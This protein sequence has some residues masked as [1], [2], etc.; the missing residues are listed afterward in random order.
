MGYTRS[1]VCNIF[2]HL[3]PPRRVETRPERQEYKC[4]CKKTKL[5]QTLYAYLGLVHR[6]T[7]IFLVGSRSF[8][9]LDSL[10]SSNKKRI[11]L[12]KLLDLS[13]TTYFIMDLKSFIKIK[14]QN[15]C[16]GAECWVDEDDDEER[17]ARLPSWWDG[18][19]STDQRAREILSG[20][21]DKTGRDLLGH[22]Q[23]T[24]LYYFYVAL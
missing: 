18:I 17:A 11:I 7:H 20:A 8:P 6:D 10:A 13:S 16:M 2:Y 21:K 12:S 15:F 19:K 24:K 5:E 22:I 23:P 14:N 9:I 4:K 3:F 1:K